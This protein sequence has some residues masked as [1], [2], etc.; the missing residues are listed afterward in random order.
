MPDISLMITARDNYT[1][2]INKMCNVS[3]RFEN[4]MVKLDG[5]LGKLNKNKA[6]LQV[7]ATKAKSEL[8]EATKAFKA[9]GDEQSKAK[10]MDAQT[11]FNNIQS[12]LKLVS[13]RAKMAEADLRG[14]TDEFNRQQNRA[15]GSGRTADSLNLGGMMS[16]FGKAGMTQMVGNV[17]SH[18]LGTFA[19]SAFGETMGN[20]I[21]ST[22]SSA[23]SGAAIGTM[24]A[25]GV[26]TLIGAAAGTVMGVVDS[27]ISTFEKKDDAFKAV[28]QER[29]DNSQ[30][31]FTDSLSNGSTI[32]A[33]REMSMMSWTTLLDSASAAKKFTTEMREFA[34]VTPYAYDDVDRM[35]KVLKTYG[36]QQAEILPTLTAVGDAGAALGMATPDIEMMATALGRMKTTDKASLEYINLLTERGIGVVDWLAERDTL[37]TAEVYDKISKGE[38]SGKETADFIAK[39]MQNS[40]S[41]AM[42]LQSLTFSGLT[43]TLNDAKAEWDAAMGEG[44]NRKR[45]PHM[46]EEIDFY[47]NETGTKV[48]EAY[49]M[50]GEYQAS[51]VN[52]QEQFKMDA[53]SAVMEGNLGLF[54]G[55]PVESRMQE[56]AAEYQRLYDEAIN[57]SGEA[58]AQ[59]GA[60]LA[61]AQVLAENEYMNSTGYQTQ[62]ETQMG[63]IEQIQADSA[64]CDNYTST[65]LKLGELFSEGLKSAVRKGCTD[66]KSIIENSGISGAY[67]YV[68]YSGGS[69]SGGG[70]PT[71]AWGQRRVPY[72]NYFTMLHEGERVLTAQEARNADAGVASVSV[73]VMGNLVVREDADVDAIAAKLAEEISLAQS[74]VI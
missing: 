61:E 1:D 2:A 25:P 46:Q 58:R 40:F 17:A 9:L 23:A 48:Q 7:D 67:I 44:F 15:G 3:K 39:Q 35:A 11:N 27:A 26:G 41:G 64:L 69:G 47:S 74:V 57:G 20:A 34:K 68:G 12:N 6:M 43:S 37:S 50:I 42:D 13:E 71:N 65:G 53:M 63:L 8:Q 14:L 60:L 49:T 32:A 45:I 56:M 22:L 54:N 55:T 59:M 19:S 73:Q 16:Q 4:Q 5:Q 28:V 33:G 24:I 31:S 62:L 38:Y 30:Q 52:L 70:T 10:L 72:D 51:L 66:A 21:S 36:Y 29:Y 18:A